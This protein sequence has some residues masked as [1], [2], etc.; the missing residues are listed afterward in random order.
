MKLTKYEHS[1]LVLEEQGLKVIIDPGKWTSEFG[2]VSNV[3]AVVV[4]HVHSDHLSAKNLKKILAENRDAAIFTTREVTGDWGDPRAQV[5][6]AGSIHEV[7]PFTLKFFGELHN[8]VH[9]EWPQNENVGVLVN[10]T[11]Y[12]PGDSFTKPDDEPVKTL[13]LPAGAPW[14]KTGEAMD[15]VK[16]LKPELFFRTHDGLWNENG[17]ATIDRWYGMAAEKFGSKYEA[18]NPGDSIEI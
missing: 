6:K 14:M 1:C 12:Y 3:V 11:L 2:D 7:G 18:L 10:G 4:T 5:V 13:A 17:L 9:P 15:F 8:A 16:E